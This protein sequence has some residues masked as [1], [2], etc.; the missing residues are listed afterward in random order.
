MEPWDNQLDSNDSQ[1]T[2]VI[3]T[4]GEVIFYPNLFSIQESDR[5]FS[6]LDS[7][8]KWRHDTIHI[9]GKKIPLPRLTAWY[10]DEGKSYIYSGIEQHPEPWNS[11][12]R[13]I[14]LKAEEISKI[15]FNSVLINLY[16]DG[17]DSVS[18]HS[19]DEPELGENPI[20]AS[21]SLGGTRRF[22]LRHKTSKDYKIDIDLPKGSLLL[23]KG[24]T[25]HFWKHQIAKTAKS[26]E[27]R[28]NLTFR[29]IK[30]VL[31]KENKI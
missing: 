13:L 19:D 10:G 6:E 27:P 14:K 26:V 7:S 9:Y 1:E 2:V 24:E 22:S 29:V 21:I 8:V 30:P 15:T 20:I 28:I 5:L 31:N 25:Q 18:W 23:M 17:K 16:R 12:L 3:D 4:D 11:T